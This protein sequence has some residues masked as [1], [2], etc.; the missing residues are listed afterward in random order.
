MFE[1]CSL[2]AK[3]RPKLGKVVDLPIEDDD[4][5]TIPA[6]HRLI[7]GGK[8]NNGKPPMAQIYAVFPPFSRRIRPS[9]C[10]RIKQ[11]LLVRPVIGA[12]ICSQNRYEAAHIT[13]QS[14]PRR[15]LQLHATPPEDST[16]PIGSSDTYARPPEP[17]SAMHTRLK[18]TTASET[19]PCRLTYSSSFGDVRS[20]WYRRHDCRIPFVA[21][22]P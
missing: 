5:T 7:A 13:T 18:C 17:V 3:D 4:I 21:A 19:G 9:M 14:L 2:S 10:N 1:T 15:R 16:S 11:T 20:S 6:L 12:R 8:V 22:F